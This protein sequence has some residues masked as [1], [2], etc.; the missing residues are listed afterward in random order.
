MVAGGAHV[1]VV[2]DEI[3]IRR[4]LRIA[5]NSEGFVVDEAATGNQAL[6]ALTMITLI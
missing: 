2:D 1:L 5:L 6:V 3:A 4:F